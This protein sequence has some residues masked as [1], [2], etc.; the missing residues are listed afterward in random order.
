[1]FS[2]PPKVEVKLGLDLIKEDGD[3]KPDEKLPLSAFT[4]SRSAPPSMPAGEKPK[5]EKS[6]F[7]PVD[8]A[9]EKKSAFELFGTP[10][11]TDNQD[12]DEIPAPPAIPS[13]KK[14]QSIFNS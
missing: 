6:L 10:P 7:G 9:K 12:K 1:M 14:N 11:P 8:V 2:K 3:A 5:K 13:L 4:A